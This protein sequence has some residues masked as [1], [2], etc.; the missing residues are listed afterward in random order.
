MNKYNYSKNYEGNIAHTNYLPKNDAPSGDC[1]V[2][3][4]GFL[5]P[6]EAVKRKVLELTCDH[7][8]LTLDMC[9]GLSMRGTGLKEKMHF[10]IPYEVCIQDKFPPYI[11]L[12]L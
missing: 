11:F 12:G 1:M 4:T 7:W 5:F 9:R 3:T 10:E 6:A 8:I 2:G